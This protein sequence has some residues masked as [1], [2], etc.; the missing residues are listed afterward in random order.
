MPLIIDKHPPDTV[1]LWLL[2]DT[3]PQHPRTLAEFQVAWAEVRADLRALHAVAPFGVTRPHPTHVQRVVLILLEMMVEWHRRAMVLAGVP[4]RD[5]VIVIDVHAA[6]RLNDVIDRMSKDDAV[7]VLVHLL[8][9]QLTQLRPPVA[10]WVEHMI[11]HAPVD[12]RDMI[13]RACRRA[14]RAGHQARRGD[15][16]TLGR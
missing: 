7:N 16:P 11:A 4:W 14:W 13:I 9:L 1:A 10:A 2:D 8:R 15:P 6:R 3:C 12:L 5:G